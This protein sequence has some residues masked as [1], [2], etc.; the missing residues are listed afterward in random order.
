V[1]AA[2]HS[3]DTMMMPPTWHTTFQPTEV[4]F[5]LLIRSTVELNRSVVYGRFTA[6]AV[7]TNLDSASHEPC[8][9]NRHL[10][11]VSVRTKSAVPGPTVPSPVPSHSTLVPALKSDS[12]NVPEDLTKVGA[13]RPLPPTSH[14]AADA[15]PDVTASPTE[16]TISARLTHLNFVMHLN[17]VILCY[18]LN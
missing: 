17:F 13:V 8:T 18:L 7:G 5:V 15:D 9:V 11:A 16:I 10:V 14:C 3:S 4:P 12:F 6:S 1:K 2:V